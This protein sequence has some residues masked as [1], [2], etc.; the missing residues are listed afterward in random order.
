MKSFGLSTPLAFWLN[1]VVHPP[2]ALRGHTHYRFLDDDM[3]AESPFRSTVQ[4]EAAAILFPSVVGDS[5]SPVISLDRAATGSS[6][7][8]FRELA[9]ALAGLRW[10][11]GQ[12]S[13]LEMPS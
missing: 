2:G 12:D 10:K 8:I 3:A 5:R 9:W 13:R 7:S 1:Q 11:T 4:R 6:C